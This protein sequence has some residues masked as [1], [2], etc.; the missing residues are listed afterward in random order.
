MKTFLLFGHG[1][2]YNRGCEAIV[3]S[4]ATLLRERFR[5]VR[6]VLVS[7]DHLR[8]EARGLGL[9][10]EIVPHTSTRWSP[11]WAA[12]R[13][14]DAVKP[15]AGNRW[16]SLPIRQVLP[17]VD[18]FL[19]I[20]GDNYCYE[21]PEYYF[22]VNELARKA[23]KPTILWGASVDVTGASR[24]KLDDLKAFD[25]ITAR[26]SLTQDNLRQI[27]IASSVALV[28]DPAF[29]MEPEAVDVAP[30]WPQGDGVLGLN[31][32]P[33]LGRYRPEGTSDGVL[34]AAADSL[35]KVIDETGLGVLLI[36]HVTQPIPP[37]EAWNDDV[38]LLSEILT[39]VSRP[40]RITLM[41]SNFTAPQTKHVLSRC[42]AFV[43]ARTHAT[44]G[45]LSMG[46]PTLSI[47][48]SLKARGI[49]L[50]LFGHL[51]HLIDVKQLAGDILTDK[52]G[53][54]IAEEESIRQRLS[55]VMPTVREMS[56]SGAGR[57]AALLGEE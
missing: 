2:Y 44:I 51:R 17:E 37:S 32:S 20:G 48:Y 3:R 36:P 40:G 29:V 21:E 25:L 16:W 6:L 19:S 14:T 8:D 11:G 1:G 18:A 33:L 5:D 31:L 50:D 27:G 9:V 30:F 53:Q 7:Y 46:V 22:H 55:E 41:P 52:I 13:L 42:R 47:G 38:N 28:A 4:T 26:E 57:L 35:R 24:R 23:G 39:E 43:G 56:R 45:A 12:A 15:G 49:N 34:R 54:L 10:D